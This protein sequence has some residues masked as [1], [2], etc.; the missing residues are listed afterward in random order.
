M[1]CRCKDL[2]TAGSGNVWSVL[3]PYC[4]IGNEA[5]S[6]VVRSYR[7]Q[8]G[9]DLGSFEIGQ[10]WCGIAV[11]GTMRGMSRIVLTR[12]VLVGVARI[13]VWNGLS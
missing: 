11:Q 8:H 10:F 12:C 5:W 6:V 7:A 1:V 3:T 2:G 9:G 13:M 4:C